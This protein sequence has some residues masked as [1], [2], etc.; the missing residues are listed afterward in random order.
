MEAIETSQREPVKRLS[1]KSSQ[2][3]IPPDRPPHVDGKSEE[4]DENGP[5]VTSEFSQLR[6]LLVEGVYGRKTTNSR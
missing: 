6:I 1:R 5:K 4:E 2:P 3:L